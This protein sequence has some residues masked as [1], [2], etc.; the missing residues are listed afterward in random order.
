MLT[1][2]G[3]LSYA[4]SDDEH[5]GGI[6]SALRLGLLGE[7]QLRVGRQPIVEIFLDR[8]RIGSGLSWERAIREAIGCANFFM[9]ILTPAF[10]QSEWCCKE[11]L[12]FRQRLGDVERQHSLIFPIYFIDI[13][14]NRKDIDRQALDYLKAFQ[15]VDLR[16]AH[17]HGI[18]RTRLATLGKEIHA[19]L[20]NAEALDP[21]SLPLPAPAAAGPEP[22]TTAGSQTGAICTPREC[23]S[24]VSGRVSMASPPLCQRRLIVCAAVAALACGVALYVALPFQ[25]GSSQPIWTDLPAAAELANKTDSPIKIFD[26]PDLGAGTLANVLPYGRIPHDSGTGIKSATID[27]MRWIW[28]IYLGKP[29]YVP[30]ADVDLPKPS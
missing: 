3:F 18:D 26:G 4:R 24:I 20:S 5:S 2:T 15:W 14:L 30:E 19:A 12:M 27:K 25:K 13:D 28:L 21:L 23:S 17:L 1:P 11:L 22:E 16:G 10:F 7:M 6:A 8:E 29:G 9:P